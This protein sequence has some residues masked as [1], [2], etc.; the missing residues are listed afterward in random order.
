MV[1]LKV[2]EFSEAIA[3]FIGPRLTQPLTQQRCTELPYPF[4]RCA[5][6]EGGSSRSRNLNVSPGRPKIGTH[7]PER[8]Q[9]IADVRSGKQPAAA[10]TI[11]RQAAGWS[12]RCGVG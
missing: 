9:L 5:S 8:R 12:L 11:A 3:A 4:S 1:W 2:D 7:S 6:A 10:L